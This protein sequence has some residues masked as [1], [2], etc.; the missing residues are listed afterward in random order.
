MFMWPLLTFG[1]ELFL[2]T[3]LDERFD[4]IMDEFAEIN[5]RVFRTFARLPVNFVICHDDIVD[6]ARAGL[7]AGVDAQARL[8]ALRGV[9]G[10]SEGRRQARRSSWPTAASTPTPTTSS[11]AARVGSSREPY[12]DWRAIARKHKDCFIAGEGDNRVLMRNDP[13]EIRAMVERMV[14]TAQHDGRLHDVHRQPYSVERAAGGDQAVSRSVGGAGASM[15]GCGV[16][17]MILI[18][19]GVCVLAAGVRAGAAEAARGRNCPG[20]ATGSGRASDKD[21]LTKLLALGVDFTSTYD[22]DP[23]IGQSLFEAGMMTNLC[24]GRPSGADL[25]AGLGLTA[26]D[27]DQDSAGHRTGEGI[28]SAV[29]AEQ[30]PDRFREYLRS[31]IT[32]VVNEPWVASVLISSPISM[33]GEVH[34]AP[35]TPGQYAVFGRQAKINFRKWLKTA[36]HDDLP[37][38]SRAWGQEIKSWDDIV[39]PEGPKAGPEGIDTRRCWSDFIH[40]YNWWLD[41]V[42]WRSLKTARE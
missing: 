18:L 34:Y 30:V 23:K 37:A 5:R 9:L 8:P 31:K 32:P 1:W 39:P 11:P 3:C 17:G 35:S 29:F 10:D 4:R 33:Y 19:V 21:K 15:R 16:S 41:E 6:L 20:W 2:E 25:I 13:A 40:W 14:E 12:T 38:L 27:M 42:T 22:N 7:L 36:Y 28:E 24:P 26:E